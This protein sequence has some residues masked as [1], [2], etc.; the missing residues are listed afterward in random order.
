MDQEALNLLDRIQLLI[1][2][3][4]SGAGYTHFNVERILLPTRWFVSYFSRLAADSEHCVTF[5]GIPVRPTDG[6]D[7]CLV[8]TPKPCAYRTEPLNS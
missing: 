6:S 4:Y 1:D 8:I 3:F 2:R 5:A 7:F